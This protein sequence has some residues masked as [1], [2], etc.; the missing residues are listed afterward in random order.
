M[1][2]LTWPCAIAVSCV[3]LV[4]AWA[5]G[6]SP[7]DDGGAQPAAAAAQPPGPVQGL[8]PGQLKDLFHMSEG[9]E[10]V[11]LAWIKALKSVKTGQPFLQVPERFGLIP[12]PSNADHL[13]IGI[14]ASPSRGAEFLGPMVGVNCAACHVGAITVSGNPTP[15]PLLGAPNLFDLNAFYQELFAS[16]GVTLK[17][18]ESREEFVANLVKQGDVEYAIL[19]EQ[20]LTAAA[21]ASQLSG[22][23]LKQTAGLFQTRLLEIVKKIVAEAESKV[24]VVKKTVVEAEAKLTGHSPS[25]AAA[26]A[27]QKAVSARLAA[28]VEKDPTGLV[29]LVLTPDDPNDPV[30]A[31]L[32]AKPDRVLAGVLHALDIELSLLRAR[33]GF[34]ASLQALHAAQRPL[35]GPGRIDAFGGI[36]DL[37]FPRSDGI[38]ADS[39]VSYPALW[40]VNQTYW[41]HWDGNTNS[42]IERNIGQAL[43]QGAPF[44]PV[45]QGHF[46]SKVK[47]RNTHKL[48]WIVRDVTPPNWPVPMFGTPDPAKVAR[49][50]VLYQERC[51]HCHAIAERGGHEIYDVLKQAQQWAVK[52]QGPPPAIPNL[53]EQLTP[54][55]KVG[56]D[57]ARAMNFATN[58]SRRKPLYTGGTDLS[59]ALGQAARQYTEQSYRDNDVPQREQLEFDWPPEM[60]RWQSTRCYV[61]RPLVSVWATAPYL[62]NA[63]V[64]TLYHLL[65]PAKDRP[66]LFPVGQRE[67]DPVK[68]GYV[69]ETGKIPPEQI[70]LLFEFNATAGGNSNA[71]HEGHD[72]GTDLNDDQRYDLLEFLK[73]L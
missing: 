10:L 12:D 72:Y 14:T 21:V 33:V 58:V 9:I 68:L 38:A 26:E 62:H 8:A 59:V 4:T 47:P 22:N 24:G 65:L 15:L 61:A 30:A 29:A 25:A 64:P 41:L 16:V 27:L 35:P 19:T 63:S 42:V 57:P 36:R 49:G 28:L 3:L 1:K 60:V 48:E 69:I 34:L 31:A 43:G 56:T 2:S 40:M 37:V 44:E 54:I 51:V 17:D 20:L 32:N 55:E 46:H 13:P 71:G 23:E 7:G 73:T 45:G 18:E 52:R 67:F 6:R 50:K 39:P 66:K 11:P 53:L 70:P 5:S